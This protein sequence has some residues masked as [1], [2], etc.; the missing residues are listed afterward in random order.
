MKAD[1]IIHALGMVDDKY[2]WEAVSTSHKTT[3][4]SFR[5][6]AAMLAAVLMVTASTAAFAVSDSLRTAAAT[7]FASFFQEKA[8]SQADMYPALSPAEL[9][10]LSSKT[11]GTV[12]DTD[13]LKIEI[14]D[15]ISS[16]KDAMVAFRITAKQLDSLLLHTG[17]DEAP[18]N[19]YRFESNGDG[20]F[21]DNLDT[22]F[23]SYIYSDT[24]P[25]LADNQL[26]LIWQLNSLH[27][28][29]EESYTVTFSKFGLR[30]LDSGFS[31]KYPGPWT[32][33]IRLNNNSDYNRTINLN[34]SMM[35][36]GKHYTLEYLHLTPLTCSAVLVGEEVLDTIS[37]LT[38]YP[39]TFSTNAGETLSPSN[40]SSSG[41][42]D[43]DQ[44]AVYHLR[45]RFE[46]PIDIWEIESAHILGETF[47]L[48]NAQ[49]L[50]Q[51]D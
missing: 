27:G 25:S 42:K 9:E 14:M 20:T 29:T 47:V 3:K 2:I 18:L 28:F 19:N 50:F 49:A 39:F 46:V 7:F 4:R 17:W 34:H 45:T 32:F 6:S 23:Y 35:I 21:F 24:D 15:I 13:E 31:V 44:P 16:G 37:T 30:Y 51:K 36:E 8:G 43:I 40:K 11:V 1:R 12:V 41:G 38:D 10:A 5:W 48:P 26:Y 22:G 33:S